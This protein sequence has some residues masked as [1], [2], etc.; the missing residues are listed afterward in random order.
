MLTILIKPISS[1]QDNYGRCKVKLRLLAHWSNVSPALSCIK[2]SQVCC[3]IAATQMTIL[4]ANPVA[5][6]TASSVASILL[7]YVVLIASQVPAFFCNSTFP[8]H[9]KLAVCVPRSRIINA[10][11]PTQMVNQAVSKVVPY[12]PL[13]HCRLALV[14]PLFPG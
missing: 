4:M 11:A 1:S 3:T 7:L 13:P 6:A 10:P 2:V 12:A 8:S 5:I 9:L 14:Y